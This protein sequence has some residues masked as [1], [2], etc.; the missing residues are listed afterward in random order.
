[1]RNIIPKGYSRPVRRRSTGMLYTLAAA[2]V[3]VWLIACI[4]A[5][6]MGGLIHILLACAVVFVVLR[7]LRGQNVF[8]TNK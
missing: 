5:L 3:V 8:G 4:A 6:T 7:T 1:L 2:L